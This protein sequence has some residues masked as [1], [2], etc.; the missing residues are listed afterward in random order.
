MKTDDY[1]SLGLSYYDLMELSDDEL[2]KFLSLTS[3]YEIIRWLQWND[4]NGVYLDHLSRK[5]Y[6]EVLK[7]EEAIEIVKRQILDA[8]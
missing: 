5:E 3:R 6:G 8:Y 4:S 1:F 2:G 7:K